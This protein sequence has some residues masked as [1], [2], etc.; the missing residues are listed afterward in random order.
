MT[1][2]DSLDRHVHVC[3]LVL[4]RLKRA[5]RDSE[6]VALLEVFQREVDDALTRTDGRDRHPGE[7]NVPSPFGVG[8]DAILFGDAHV[9][10]L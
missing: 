8:A 1:R 6:L 5:N 9:R 7:G 3:G 10:E 4:E 2:H